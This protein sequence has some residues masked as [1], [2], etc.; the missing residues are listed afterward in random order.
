[1]CERVRARRAYETWF[2]SVG[3]T[4]SSREWRTDV[5]VHSPSRCNAALPCCN[6]V[7]RTYLLMY[8][9]FC[10][11]THPSMYLVVYLP[12][13]LP[14]PV[15]CL[16]LSLSGFAHAC[17][18]GHL[19]VTRTG[20]LPCRADLTFQ[21]AFKKRLQPCGCAQLPLR[22][23]AVTVCRRLAC[24]RSVNFLSP[25]PAGC[26]RWQPHRL[27]SLRVPRVGL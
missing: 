25:F 5:H 26:P 14:T 21:S 16:S 17:R 13:Y 9:S 11:S 27:R 24:S 6:T 8:P 10:A 15:T 12:T 3:P 19:Q 22:G 4:V 20:R 7:Q 2:G 23:R 18:V 1:M